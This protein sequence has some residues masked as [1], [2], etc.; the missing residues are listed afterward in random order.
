MGAS[1]G[2]YRDEHKERG[3]SMGVVLEMTTMR[4]MSYFWVKKKP[5]RKDKK[6]TARLF[7][8]E[9]LSGGDG[10]YVMGLFG[11]WCERTL[12]LHVGEGLLA[13]VF[14]IEEKASYKEENT[15]YVGVVMEVMSETRASMCRWRKL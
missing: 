5:I 7:V 1:L 3:A 9:G 8:R 12:E 10:G 2:T 6:A 15:C 13:C 4:H 14:S 11:L